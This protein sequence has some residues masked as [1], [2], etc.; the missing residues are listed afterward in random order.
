MDRL[1]LAQESCG[2]EVLSHRPC[3]QQTRDKATECVSCL[4]QLETSCLFFS[5]C[6]ALRVLNYEELREFSERA[7]GYTTK[8]R[9]YCAD[10]TCSK[11]IPPFAID[12]DHGTCPVCQ[13]KTHLPCRSLE[14]PGVDCPMDE[15]LQHVLAMA[16][17]ANWQRCFHC[18][19]MVK[20]QHGC[21]HM[22]R[23]CGRE[24]CYVC[25]QKW[26]TCDFELWYVDRLLDQANRAVE[27]EVAP[28]A[29]PHIRRRAF[30]RAVKDLLHHED[31]WCEHHRNSQWAWRNQGSLECAFCSHD[32]PEYIFMCKDCRMRACNRCRRHRL[33]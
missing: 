5:A 10:P 30:D 15:T 19:T 4:E 24:F 2:G 33:R 7:L 23:R 9:V 25:D 11:F 20:L 22:T 26:K 29:D 13:Q 28:D 12:D 14:H 16:N 18:R 3:S 6:T 17:A 31:I 1:N 27:D 21:N 8:D 32:L